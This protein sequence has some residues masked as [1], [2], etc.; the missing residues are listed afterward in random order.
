MKRVY[1]KYHDIMGDCLAACIASIFELELKDVPNFWDRTLDATVFWT[2]VSK[3]TVENLGHK[4]IVVE[5][6]KENYSIFIE[7][8]LCIALVKD[9][10]H[11]VVWKNGIIHDPI[12][13]HVIYKPPKYFVVF[14]PIEVVK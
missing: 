4:T 2:L 1:Q 5:C 10:N 7:D 14:T 6:N 11:A 12:G 9:G 13:Y 8:V 3:W